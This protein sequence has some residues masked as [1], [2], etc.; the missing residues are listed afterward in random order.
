MKC[1]LSLRLQDRTI[2]GMLREKERETET[3]KKREGEKGVRK[4]RSGKNL[5]FSQVGR[6][7]YFLRWGLTM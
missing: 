7:F 6:I 5:G 2:W 3:K 1:R 4:S